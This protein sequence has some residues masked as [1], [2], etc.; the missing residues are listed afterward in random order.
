M[1][2][3]IDPLAPVIGD[4]SKLWEQLYEALG[5][6][7]EADPAT[8]Y[9]LRQFCEGWCG[10]LQPV[11]EL[12]RERDDGPAWAILFDVDE[13]PAASLPYLAQYVGVVLTPEMSEADIRE[14]IRE[15]VGWARGRL[16]AIKISGKPTLTGTRRV[17]VRPRT[18]VP[19]AHYIRT[20][21][22]ETPEEERTRVRLRAAVPAW[23]VL[24]YEAIAGVTWEDVAAGWK[25]FAALTAAFTDFGDLA[26]TLPT[27]LPEP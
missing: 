18:P 22:T 3:V 4:G 5:Y 23:E 12:V 9:A 7:Q 14:A 10:T 16:P 6:H 17:I 19:G 27:E 13:C 8:G 15:P 26:D 21:A 1:T 25:D 2:V 20:L 24:D 11:H